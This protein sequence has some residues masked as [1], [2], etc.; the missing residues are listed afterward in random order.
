MSKKKFVQQASA[1]LLFHTGDTPCVDRAVRWAEALWEKLTERGYGEARPHQPRQNVDYYTDLS[2]RQRQWFDR[3]WAAF[4]HKHNRNRAAMRWAQLG[5]LP[6]DK[7]QH[8]VDAAAQENARQLPPGQSRK[9]AEGWLAD[10]RW[11]DYSPVKK[12]GAEASAAT[13]R[14]LLMG[15]LASLQQLHRANPH[16]SMA[17]RIAAI[18]AQLK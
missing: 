11:Q 15:E 3:F 4:G 9:M 18:K 2:A 17:E 7:Y 12:Q 10:L 13:E 14:A 8:I 1:M 5:E 16:P 6:D